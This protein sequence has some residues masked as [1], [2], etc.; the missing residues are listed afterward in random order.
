MTPLLW[1]LIAIQI[2]MGMFD[3]FYHHEF[4]E[5]LAWRPSQRGELRLHSVRN[6]FYALLFLTLG[7]FEIHGLLAMLVIAVLAA[8]IIIT[9]MDFVE[10]DLSRK[11]PPS[12][13][14]NHTLLA[15]NYGAILVLLL[16]VLVGWAMRPTG[17]VPAYAGLLSWFAAASAV[18]AALFGLR[19]FVAARRLAAMTTAPAGELVGVMR[20]PQ[21]VLVTGATG[22]VGSRLAASLSAAGH[23]VIALVRDPTKALTLPLPITLI[24]SLD[25]LAADTRIDAVVNLAGEPINNGLWTEAK[26]QAIVQSRVGMT[27]DVVRLIARLDRKPE[28][29]VNGSAIGWYGLWQ[30]QPLT[31]SA[32]SHASFSHDLCEAWEQA[33]RGAEAHGVRVAALRIGLVVGR[34]GGFLARLLTPFEFGLGGPIGSGHQWMSWIERDDLVRLIAHVIMSPDLA[35]PINATAPLPVRNL[36]FTAELAH[37]LHRPAVFRIPA[38]LLRRV[39]GDLANELLLGGQRVVPNKALS[40]GFVFRHQSLRSALQ[41][42]L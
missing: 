3:T 10:E 18:G 6:V 25:Q 33:A 26:R 14:I 41:A 11:L 38:T 28:V 30:D 29:L 8:E 34:D 27:E 1:T 42:I 22:F 15:I 24:T 21:T 4:T 12:E 17:I 37:R 19:D 9:L 40:H 32:K 5:R 39:G 23:H 13:R 16:P 20:A 2:A 35:G 31:E 7:W 36:T